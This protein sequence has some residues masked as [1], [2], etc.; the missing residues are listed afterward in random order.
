M[1]LITSKYFVFNHKN[2]QDFGVVNCFFGDKEISN[3]H[4]TVQKEEFNMSNYKLNAY[5]T[6][7]D[8]PISFKFSIVKC[9]E[10]NF[11]QAESLEINEWLMSPKIYKPFQFVYEPNTEYDEMNLHYYAICTS[12]EDEVIN[13]LN[14]KT[15]TFETN[16]SYAFMNVQKERLK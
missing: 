4:R 16:S 7:D 2:S 12:I 14:G 8:E 11:T 5:G 6:I 1:S 13:G 10:E 9:D 15:L 3:I